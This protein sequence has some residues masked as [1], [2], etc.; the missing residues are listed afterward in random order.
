MATTTDSAVDFGLFGPGSVAWQLHREPGLLIGGL[1]APLLQAPPPLA[2]AA[3]EQ[4]SDYKKDVWGRFNRT[5][6]HVVATGFGATHQA[7]PMGPRGRALPPPT[8]GLDP[9][10]AP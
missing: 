2:I 3:V 5:P 10:P 9:A 8:P 1:R 6:N 4:H 7:N